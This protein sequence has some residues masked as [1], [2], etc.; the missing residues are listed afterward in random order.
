MKKRRQVQELSPEEYQRLKGM[1]VSGGYSV[2]TVGRVCGV[3]R[4]FAG[5]ALM[6]RSNSEKAV[7]CR[8]MALAMVG[9][10]GYNP[11]KP[12]KG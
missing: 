1:L 8:E 12:K 6:G 3:S 2:S 11:W 9:V 7:Q 5:R 10:E 4:A